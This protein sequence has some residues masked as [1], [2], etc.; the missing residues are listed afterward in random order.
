[1]SLTDLTDVTGT[2]APNKS[3]VYNDT[4][5]A[6]LTEITTRQDLDDVLD[7]VAA[8]N[9]HDIGTPGEPP[10]LS[11]FRNIGDPWSPARFRVLANSTVR[12]QGNSSTSTARSCR[13][14]ICRITKPAIW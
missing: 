4:G 1:M 7:Q 2:P 3:P 6:P 10:F 5:V 9:W 12:L 13:G 11:Q 8:V 14:S